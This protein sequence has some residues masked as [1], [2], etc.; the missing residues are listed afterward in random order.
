MKARDRSQE[1]LTLREDRSSNN[2]EVD[3]KRERSKC[4]I[5]K[6]DREHGFRH[7]W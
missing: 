7:V 4:L 1:K 6:T 3:A 2:R 5:R